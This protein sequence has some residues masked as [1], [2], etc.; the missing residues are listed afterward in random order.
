[1][2]LKLYKFISLLIGPFVD[3]YFMRRKKSGKEDEIRFS[4]RLGHANH[5]RPEGELMWIHAASVG[6]LVSIIPLLGRLLEQHPNINALITTGTV[7]SANIAAKRLPERAFHQYIP[8]DSIIF[9]RRFLSHWRPDIALWVESELWPN[10]ITEAHKS[11]CK[12]VQVN[13]RISRS[14]FEKWQ[15]Y[16]SLAR[17]MISCFALSLAQSEDDCARLKELGAQDA[18]YIGNLKYDAPPL[19]ADPEQTAQMIKM[20]GDRPVWVAAS[21]HPGEEE[22]IIR[23]HEHL[24]QKYDKLFTIII[25]RHPE[26]GREIASLIPPS[27]QYALRSE[28]AAH[29]NNIDIYIADTIGEIGLFY[30]LA[31]IVFIGGSLVEH[32]GQNPLEAARLECA[33]FTGPYTDNFRH[34]YK[35]MEAAKAI[36][37]I[38]DEETLRKAISHLLQNPDKQEEYQKAAQDFIKS[39]QGV[40]DK[41]AS[42]LSPHFKPF[43]RKTK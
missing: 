8:V 17:K 34:I 10:L 30:R 39:K 13:A 28:N 15:R 32:G 21:T 36:V 19:P 25:P 31:G 6:E 11:G 27:M 35:E 40:L 3:I 29:N 41:I 20:V 7:T 2:F 18:R 24:K 5:V 14:S 9:V 37:R 26:R 4:E 43:D 16:P 12:M 23:T 22:I 33:L 42:A 1:M 38:R